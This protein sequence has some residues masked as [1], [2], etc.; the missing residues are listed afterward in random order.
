MQK[1]LNQKPWQLLKLCLFFLI[2][3]SLPHIN[4]KVFYLFKKTSCFYQY[5]RYFFF[6]S[7]I[8]MDRR[9]EG[10]NIQYFMGQSLMEQYPLKHEGKSSPEDKI[11]AAFFVFQRSSAFI[12]KFQ[13]HFQ[14]YKVQRGF[15]LYSSI[16]HIHMSKQKQMVIF[17]LNKELNYIKY[18]SVLLIF[19]IYEPWLT[20]LIVIIINPIL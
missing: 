11:N 1:A 18:Q 20:V 4:V 3:C 7:T 8:L 6:K 16:F 19:Q 17:F 2:C 12:S 14:K 15:Q 5:I 10:S 13:N 9:Q